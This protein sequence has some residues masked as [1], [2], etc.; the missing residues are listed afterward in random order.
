MNGNHDMIDIAAPGLKADHALAQEL[1]Q[2]VAALLRRNQTSFPGAQPVSF[3]RKHMDELKNNEY[4]LYLTL[5]VHDV[6]F[7]TSVS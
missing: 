4:V 6:P 3:S 5:E 1:R 7:L 2:E